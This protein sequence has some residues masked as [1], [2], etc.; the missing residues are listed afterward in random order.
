M[1]LIDLPG[2]PLLAHNFNVT[3]LDT[4]QDAGAVITSGLRALEATLSAGFSTCSGLDM[5]LDMEEYAEGGRNGTV[6]RFPTRTKP[7]NITLQRGVGYSDDLWNWF[8]GFVEGK[9]RRRAGVI[10]MQN[11]LR[12]PVKIWVF[13]RA[14]P[15][16]WTG[17]GLDAARSQVAIEEIKFAP[18]TLVLATPSAGI[19]SA[20]GVSL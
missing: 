10:T 7:G 6:L 14:L 5:T 20:T 8:N 19:S 17:P 13:T 2:T 11:D 3:L 4:S 9:G 1:G 15:V 12:I 16:K 18:E